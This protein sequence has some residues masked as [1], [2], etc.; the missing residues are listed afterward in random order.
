M[1]SIPILVLLFL[2]LATPALASDGVLEINQ[3]CAVNTGCFAGDTAGFP[4]TVLDSGSY[5]LTGNLVVADENTTA[6]T[7]VANDASIDLGG[8]TIKGPNSCSGNPT[9]CTLSGTGFG[10]EMVGNRIEVFNG[11]VTG[12]GSVGIYGSGT[13][14]NVS[15]HVVHDVRVSQNR[16]QGVRING[17]AATLRESVVILNGTNGIEMEGATAN[18]V[19]NTVGLNGGWGISVNIG[20][21]VTGN[22]IYSNGGTG[23]HAF[24]GSTIQSNSVREN[25]GIG[26]N[27]D[28]STAFRD[29]TITGNGGG[30]VSG[31]G[32]AGGN[33]CNGSLT[34][35]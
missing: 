9:T 34:C 11:S 14:S 23:I 28:T 13:S 6:I 31:G 20:A 12:L 7:V 32:N 1:R 17:K 24:N 26:M 16:Y 15:G 3:T 21:T 22:R 2:T 35:P 25:V 33:V 27:L 30:T 8:F 10:V 19:D 4:V 18:V 5:R 29:N